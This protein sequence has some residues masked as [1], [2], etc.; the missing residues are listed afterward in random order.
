MVARY[1]FEQFANYWERERERERERRCSKVST[2]IRR[3]VGD[4]LLE[5]DFLLV[6]GRR[7]KQIGYFSLVAGNNEHTIET[8]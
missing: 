8:L 2:R 4:C 7:Q 5:Q 3:S 6:I 1:L